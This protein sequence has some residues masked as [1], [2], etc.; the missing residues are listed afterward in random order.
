MMRRFLTFI[1][2]ILLTACQD[3]PS[4]AEKS[5][6]Q[7]SAKPE[8]IVA[9]VES[10]KEDLL[11]GYETIRKHCPDMDDATIKG[12]LKPASPNRPDYDF[13]AREYCVSHEEARRRLALQGEWHSGKTGKMVQEL[14]TRIKLEE[15]DS[16][17]GHWIQHTPEYGLAVAFT[18]D[19]KETLAKYTKDP[20]FFPVDIQG[21]D[22]RTIDRNFYRIIAMLEKLDIPYHS[23]NRDHKTGT[24]LVQLSVDKEDYIRGLA[25]KGEIDLPEWVRFTA[26]PPLPRPVPAPAVSPERLK[27]FPHYRHRREFNAQS[28]MGVRDIKGIL[29]LVDGCLAF[30]KDGEHNTILW[31]KY[32][33][34]DLT[35]S[36]RVGVMSRYKDTTIFEN[37]EVVISGLQP[38]ITA[39]VKRF[40][41]KPEQWAKVADDTDESCPPPYVMV[42]YVSSL[43]ERRKINFEAKIKT[44]MRTLKLTREQ[45]I[46]EA[47]KQQATAKDLAVFIK[48]IKE[49]HRNVVA[50]A[51]GPPADGFTIQSSAWSNERPP[52]ASIFVKGE[53]DKA[54]F[55]PANLIE[56]V[57]VQSAPRSLAEGDMDIAFL[58]EHLGETASFQF[59]WHDGSI[60]IDN[61]TDLRRLSRLKASLGKDWPEHYK[62]PIENQAVNSTYFGPTSILGRY[63]MQQ[64]P[65]YQGI[66]EYAESKFPEAGYHMVDQAVLTLMSYG[67]TDLE[68]I[69]RLEGLGFG[70]LTAELDYQ[71]DSRKIREAIYAEAIVTAKRVAINTNDDKG[72]GY[73]STVT[74]EVKEA[75]KGRLQTGETFKVRLKSGQDENGHHVKVESEPFL[76][77]GFYYGFADTDDDLR[78]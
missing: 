14:I 52:A 41:N 33:A 18:K 67:L 21:T 43:A 46:I 2:L 34:P 66:L 74:F 22:E 47:E 48:E 55:I 19:A 29:K 53:V 6:Q 77:P 27:A 65:E 23:A 73:R 72:D 16:F 59:Q 62:I 40:N 76:L 7:T 39:Q 37:E 58:K 60:S 1:F 10:A 68:E 5:A 36:E 9:N 70:P 42:E 51:W 4:D 69:K 13:Y 26:P 30:E 8:T 32:H 75:V 3:G 31:Q 50:G 54:D 25:A 12:I 45:A 49:N 44:L 28:S 63:E 38:E 71:S 35:N 17:A 11:E 61:I 57:H 78:P 56:Y 15:A 64:R 24:F 20:I